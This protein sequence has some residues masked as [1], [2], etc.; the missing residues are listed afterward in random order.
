MAEPGCM[1]IPLAM[2]EALNEAGGEIWRSTPV[3]EVIIEDEK[4][5]GV[6]VRNKEGQY[7]TFEAPI[8]ICNIPPKHIFHVLH[9]RHFPAEWVD[10]LQNE[11]WSPG[12][13][14]ALIGIKELYLDAGDHSRR[15]YWGRGHGHVEYGLLREESPGREE[16]LHF[17]N[18]LDR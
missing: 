6:M 12:L 16:G 5:R 18:R 8:V 10:M 14:S 4:V 2:E 1:A 17:L 3:E 9:P 15:L 13:L 7:E 11:F